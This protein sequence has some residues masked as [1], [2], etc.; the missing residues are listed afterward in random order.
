MCPCMPACCLIFPSKG[1]RVMCGAERQ[2]S[3]LFFAKSHLVLHCL[4]VAHTHTQSS[5][6][7]NHSVVLQ[8]HQWVVEH[9]CVC[10]CVWDR[11]R[12]Y[13]SSVSRGF[14]SKAGFILFRSMFADWFVACSVN[15]YETRCTHTQTHKTGKAQ[16]I[17]LMTSISSMDSTMY[18]RIGYNV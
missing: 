3:H 13:D 10:L 8:S 7:I 1:L 17:I 6:V 18:L 15:Q 4:F 16:Y 11:I 2:S 9:N 12:G 14:A 5:G